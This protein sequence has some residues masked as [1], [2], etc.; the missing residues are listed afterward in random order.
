V[1]LSNIRIHQ[2]P[3]NEGYTISVL[4]G[5]DAAHQIT[6]V[7]IQDFLIDGKRVTNADDLCLYQKQTANLSI[8]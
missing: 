1:V 4:G 7:V 8:S 2:N 5:W 3:F 6:D